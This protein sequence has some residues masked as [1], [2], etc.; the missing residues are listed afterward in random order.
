[1][2]LLVLVHEVDATLQ[3]MVISVPALASPIS[4]VQRGFRP[5]LFQ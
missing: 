2:D 5:G 1:V 3:S 4:S